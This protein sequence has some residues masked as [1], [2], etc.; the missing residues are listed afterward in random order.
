MTFSSFLDEKEKEEAKL[1]LAESLS[2]LGE[3]LRATQLIDEI[4]SSA[5]TLRSE[6][7][8]SASLLRSRQRIENWRM[9]KGEKADP[10]IQKAIVEL[11]NLIL[12]RQLSHEP[13]HLEAALDY[14]ALQT[15]L[16]LSQNRPE[17]NLSLLLKVKADFESSSDLLSK[18]YHESRA[19]LPQ[20]NRILEGYLRLIDAEIFIAQAQINLEPDSQNKLQ[21]KAKELLLQIVDDSIHPRL[22]ERARMQLEKTDA[23]NVSISQIKK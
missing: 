5:P 2:A 13:L 6:T 8:A 7:A 1:L 14:V 11:K 21:A 23:Q 3:K 4:L 18:D 9:R 19:K 17:K 22:V 16:D 20:K 12:Q 10:E 15:E